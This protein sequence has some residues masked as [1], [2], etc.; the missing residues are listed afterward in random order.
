MRREPWL[1]L[2]SQVKG[3]N[4]SDPGPCSKL[5]LRVSEMGSRDKLSFWERDLLGEPLALQKPSKGWGRGS[6]RF[7]RW[8]R[9][10]PAG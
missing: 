7:Q 3:C 8:G 10:S 5:L 6:D 1:E 4:F 9:D 2:R